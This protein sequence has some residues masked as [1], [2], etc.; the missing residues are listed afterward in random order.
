MLQ[1]PNSLLFKT[2]FLCLYV[3]LVAQAKNLDFIFI[4]SFP[5]LSYVIDQILFIL[6]LNLG[7]CTSP[8]IDVFVFFSI[9]DQIVNIL[10]IADT[11]SFSAIVALHK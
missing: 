4:S 3:C 8:G 1:N 2:S 11:V 7:L 6:V 9:K 10:Y 5:H